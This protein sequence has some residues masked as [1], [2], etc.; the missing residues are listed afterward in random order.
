MSAKRLIKRVHQ[1][2][3]PCVVGRGRP[4]MSCEGKVKYY[5]SERIGR[6]VRGLGPRN[7]VRNREA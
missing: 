3:G 2:S 4:P 6:G 5:L 7:H 1:S